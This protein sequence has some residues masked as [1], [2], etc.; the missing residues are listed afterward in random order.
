[1]V[2]LF[3]NAVQFLAT[4]SAGVG[5]GLLYYKNRKQ[6]YFLLACFFGTFSL[7]TLYW[8][9][10]VLL[11]SQTPQVFYVSE[12]GWLASYMFLL[13]LEHTLSTPEER[14]FWHPAVLLVPAVCVPQLLLYMTRGDILFNLP[15][16]G[17]TMAAGW[18]S[19]RGLLYARRQSGKP[20]D[21]QFF[22]IAVLCAVALEFC[23]WTVSCF[24]AGDT[25]ANP[26]F[27]VD[28]FLSASLFA[29]LPATKKAV[30]A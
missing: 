12:L 28:F 16:C 7:G 24:W 18:Y 26:Y 6:E 3:D 14:R 17:M 2:E 9:L 8:T 27:W 21:R 11:F 22:H 15:I 5:A 19:V 10:N 29:L 4:L 13:T 30:G 1:M 23:L 20:R 25:L